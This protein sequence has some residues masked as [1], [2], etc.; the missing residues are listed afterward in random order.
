VTAPF[1]PEVTRLLLAWRGGDDD[2]LERLMPLVYRELRTL[3]H[4]R[5]RR[6]GQ[7]HTL[8]TTALVNEA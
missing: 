8:Q 3:A 7:R 2:A 1:A 6:E 4:A 5:M